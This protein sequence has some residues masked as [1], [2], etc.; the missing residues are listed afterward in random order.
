[1]TAT[2]DRCPRQDNCPT[3]ALRGRASRK[4]G[5]FIITIE[6]ML[7]ITILIIGSLAGIVAVRDALFKHYVNRQAQTVLVSDANGVVLGTPVDFDE[8]EAPRIFY[9]DR[10]LIP[11]RRALI[12][13]RDDRFTGREPLYYQGASCRGEPC[14]KRPSD[15]LVD[16]RSTDGIVGTGA[17]GYLYGLQGTPTYAI[18]RSPDGLPGRLYRETLDSC[19]FELDQVGSRWLSQKVVA[20]E[21]CEPYVIDELP[22]VPA[23]L[24]CLVNLGQVAGVSCT[25][26]PEGYVVQTDILDQAGLVVGMDLKQLLQAQGTPIPGVLG[27]QLPETRVGEVYCPAGTRLD[28]TNLIDLVVAYTLDTLLE[29]DPL[30]APTIQNLLDVLNLAPGELQCLADGGAGILMLAESVPGAGDP[31]RNALD[32]LTPPFQL[33]LPAA[34]D[35][36]SWIHTPPNEEGNP[37]FLQAR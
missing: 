9:I 23:Y 27:D 35:P 34:T 15:E 26:V 24:G 13:I 18:G 12:G 4:Q 1:M 16:S 17:V 36:D 30:L 28:D 7:I 6:L 19:P 21:P 31:G 29:A 8:H 20:G 3:V 22:G 10:S 25:G 37:A 5:G 2:N 33:N 11:A 32:G 14:I